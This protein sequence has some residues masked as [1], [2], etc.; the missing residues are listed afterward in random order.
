LT[1]RNA[2]R[3]KITDSILDASGRDVRVHPAGMRNFNRLE[4]RRSLCRSFDSWERAIGRE[5][6]RTEDTLSITYRS[7]PAL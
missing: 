7:L 1:S 6:R 3:T 4:I 2:G 5:R